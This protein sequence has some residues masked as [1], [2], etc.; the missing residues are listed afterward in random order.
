MR[1]ASFTDYVSHLKRDDNSIWK[2]IRNKNRP[3]TSFPPI[4][5]YITP[6][7]TWAK[8]DNEISDLFA[9]RLLRVI[10]PNNTDL[11]QDV[12]RDLVTTIQPSER[13]K[14]FS[15][16]ELTKEIKLLNPRRAP[17]R[18]L[19][20]AQ[21]LKELQHEGFLNLLTPSSDSTPGPDL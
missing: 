6:P 15:L 18:K 5:K 19:I 8:S 20:T 9:D 13:L 2:P 1:N 10:S 11:N 17:G 3:Q 21:M 14:T 4:R 12:E 7:G 16:Q